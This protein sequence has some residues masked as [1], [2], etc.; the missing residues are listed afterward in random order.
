MQW[1]PVRQ[2]CGAANDAWKS[3]NLIIVTADVA[4]VYPRLDIHF[5]V[6]K[7]CKML[8]ESIE[9]ID[10]DCYA[11]KCHNQRKMQQVVTQN[12]TLTRIVTTFDAKC[13]TFFNAN[14]NNLLTQNVTSSLTRIVTT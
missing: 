7:V 14:C 5:T 12:I 10:Y 3:D 13:N 4:A 9:G 8:F 2:V 11:A 6:D 1:S